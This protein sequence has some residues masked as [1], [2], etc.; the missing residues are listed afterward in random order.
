L[1]VATTQAREVQ[2]PVGPDVPASATRKTILTYATE[3]HD[4]ADS[5]AVECVASGGWPPTLVLLLPGRSHRDDQAAA[6]ARFG[7]Y[8]TAMGLGPP[9]GRL[10]VQARA[11]RCRGEPFGAESAEAL[12]QARD[13]VSLYDRSGV[14]HLQNH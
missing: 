13:L 4:D 10:T 7:V 2:P 1:F 11:G 6:V 14:A 8:V 3:D 9:P 5:L 12:E